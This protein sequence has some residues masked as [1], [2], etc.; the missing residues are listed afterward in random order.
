LFC[1]SV[2]QFPLSFVLIQEGDDETAKTESS[3]LMMMSV[4]KF[5][6]TKCFVWR[7]ISWLIGKIRLEFHDVFKAPK[8]DF[9]KASS[10][11]PK[12]Y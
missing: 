11:L 5:E 2:P 12:N 3:S 8:P 7:R 9:H 4:I 10:K 1:V 6:V